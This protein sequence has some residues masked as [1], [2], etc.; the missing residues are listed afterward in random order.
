MTQTGKQLLRIQKELD[1]GDDQVPWIPRKIHADL[2]HLD[3]GESGLKNFFPTRFHR[4]PNE[5]YMKILHLAGTNQ[6]QEEE[7]S[8]GKD[9]YHQLLA[10]INEHVFESLF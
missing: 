7:P 4:E 3:R 10:N 8:G 6:A 9:G 2:W 5:A 1:F